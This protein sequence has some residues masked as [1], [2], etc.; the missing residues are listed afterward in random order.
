MEYHVET[1]PLG[2]GEF[3]K[4]SCAKIIT[5]LF[6]EE[7][8]IMKI[9][10]MKLKIQITLLSNTKEKWCRARRQLNEALLTTGNLSTQ[11]TLET[12]Q[13]RRL[14][15]WI[16]YGVQAWQKCECIQG[17]Q[18]QII[19]LTEQLNVSNK[20]PK[21]WSFFHGTLFFHQRKTQLPFARLI[22]F[23]T[24]LGFYFYK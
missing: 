2:Q 20:S 14:L 9:F 18:K 3:R 11:V 6:C 10:W 23:M 16:I 21:T 17:F 19:V 12:L 22:V 4:V 13:F 7:V 1:D 15:L 24:R 8:R 5:L